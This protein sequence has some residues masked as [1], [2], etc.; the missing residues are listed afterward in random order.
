[1]ALTKEQQYKLINRYQ[2]VDKDVIKEIIAANEGLV[3]D[4]AYKYYNIH[5]SRLRMVWVLLAKE[6]VKSKTKH[7]KS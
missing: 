7:I 5:K 3:W 2:S 4:S 6:F 1:M